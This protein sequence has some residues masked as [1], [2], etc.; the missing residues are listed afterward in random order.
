M[1]ESG[2]S[3]SLIILIMGASVFLTIL[4]R[5][6]SRRIG[7]PSI[8]GF[9][10]LGFFIRL[11]DTWSGCLSTGGEEIFEFLAKLGIITLLFRIG[12]ESN[13][14][15]LLHQLR[16]ASFIWIGGVLVSGGL[17][18]ITCYHLLHLELINSLFIS[19][20]L[21]ATS[22]GIPVGV[23]QE[24]E[25]IQ[26]ERGEL[27]VDVAE[28]DDISG[29]VL[30]ALM[31]AIAPV[32][33][34]EVGSSA[35][36]PLLIQAVGVILLKL[37][38]FGALCAF[39]SLY[40]ERH[41]TGFFKNI[42]SSPDPMIVIAGVGIMIASI[43]GL[44][45][46]SVAIGAFFAGLVFSRDPKSVKIDASFETLYEFFSPFFFIGIGLSIEPSSL[47]AS[48]GLG[49]ILLVIAI[50]GKVLGHG[51]PTLI[52]SGWIG[53]LLIGIS[54]I[55]RAEITMII[56]KHGK[57]LGDWAVTPATFTAMVLVSG[58]TCIF[59]PIII[60]RLLTK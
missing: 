2:E 25:E 42:E 18:F 49:F 50:L 30:M 28:M 45:G 51:V 58:A 1:S 22:V 43:A 6:G 34:H 53:A 46:F 48:M 13:V 37:V 47:T 16:R 7:I 27:L 10:V 31:L 32:L 14:S 36:F 26:S 8:V 29:I 52:T 4:I 59:S 41:I 38:I 17:G 40:I 60:R 56:M 24:A 19:V 5:S 54:M 55:P 3:L 20:A 33:K 15:G 39:F 23:W 11:M 44:L 9:M 21:T 57:N 35:L 12:L